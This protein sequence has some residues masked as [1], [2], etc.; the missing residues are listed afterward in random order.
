MLPDNSGQRRPPR[1]RWIRVLTIITVLIIAMYFSARLIGSKIIEGQMKS[2]T[3]FSDESPIAQLSVTTTNTNLKWKVQV[4]TYDSSGNLVATPQTYLEPCDHWE[5]KANIIS[6]QPW[7][8]LDVPSGWYMLT[9]LE[10]SHCYDL[11][12]KPT[13]SIEKIPINGSTV[14]KTP[15]GGF[16]NSVKSI[17]VASASIQPDGKTYNVIITPTS[18]LLTPTG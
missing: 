4:S 12:G 11:H 5:L 6:I 9:N 13:T 3:P 7:L 2:Y 16:L 8:A 15:D 14:L 1:R 18:V 17:P 10:G